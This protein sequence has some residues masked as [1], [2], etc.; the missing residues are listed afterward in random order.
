MGARVYNP[1]VGRF[2]ST[3]PVVGGNENAYDYPNDPINQS[4][5]SGKKKLSSS[6]TA[7]IT[8]DVRSIRGGIKIRGV[9]LTIQPWA[10]IGVIAILTLIGS[11][12]GMAA[13]INGLITAL[14][15][16]VGGV[17]W[18]I[19]GIIGAAIGIAISLLGIA[20]WLADGKPITV[21][22]P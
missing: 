1:T 19:L 17:F 10:I 20:L 21:R 12:I 18:A 4:D 14:A 5:T 22:L 13:A 8:K 7:K 6:V 2:T 11:M 9:K 15:P 3:D 16:P